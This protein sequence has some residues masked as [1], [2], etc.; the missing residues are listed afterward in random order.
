[1]ESIFAVARH[2]DNKKET[3]S[4]SVM[5]FSSAKFSSFIFSS[6]GSSSVII[7]FELL[8]FFDFLL[9]VSCDNNR[10]RNAEKG[11]HF[12]EFGNNFTVDVNCNI[13]FIVCSFAGGHGS[14]SFVVTASLY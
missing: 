12:A 10:H 14:G 5:L 4:E 3:T 11:A 9:H 13:A 1:M 8:I 2:L 7:S 6:C